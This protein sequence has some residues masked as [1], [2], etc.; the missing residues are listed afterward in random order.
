[1]KRLFPILQSGMPRTLSITGATLVLSFFNYMGLTV[2][3]YGAV[4]LGIISLLPFVLMAFISIPKIQ[5]RRW[6]TLGE[7]GTKTD[8]TLYFNT[9]FWNLNFWDNASTLA[10]EVDKPQ[11]TFPKALFS[12]GILTCLGYLIPLLAATGSLSVNQS[13]WDDGYLAEAGY[14]IAGNWLKIWIEVGSVL[15]SIGLFEAQLSSSSYQLLGMADLGTLPRFFGWRAR[16]FNTPWIGILVCT[17]FTIGVSYLNFTDIV[18]SA[19]FLYSFGMILEFA[20]FL[21]LRKKYPTMN[22]PYKVPLGIP[23]LTIMCLIPTGFIIYVCCIAT[24]MVYLIS[25]SL[26]LLGVVLYW[27]MTV[28]KSKGWMEFTKKNDD[29]EVEQEAK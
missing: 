6:L 9:L 19:N 1:M 29:T 25:G 3:G 10:G 16:Y 17:I 20:S 22:R 12:A 4:S 5:P 26:I 8:W 28:I 15:S 27:L 7:K 21:W 2:V 24:K 13:V 18:S 23:A 11:S 14:L